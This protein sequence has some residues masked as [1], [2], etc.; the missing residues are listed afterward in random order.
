MAE[1]K[2]RSPLAA[3]TGGGALAM[4]EITGQALINLRGRADCEPFAAAVRD[5]LGAPLPVAPNTTAAAGGRRIFW[6]GPDE[7]LVRAP[8]TMRGEIFT[9]LQKTRAAAE[10]HAA[11]VDVSDYYTIIRIAGARARDAL[12]AGCPLDL[13]PQQ[14]AVGQCAQ[15]RFARAAI[16]LWHSSDAPEFEL[17]VRWSFAEYLWE[18]LE[19][20][21]RDYLQRDYLPPQTNSGAPAATQKAREDAP[22]T[23][24]ESAPKSMLKSASETASKTAPKNAS[25]SAS[26]TARKKHPQKTSPVSSPENPRAAGG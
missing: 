2:T 17:Q 22:K 6:L 20:H 26:K 21:E 12:A 15:S 9:A 14:F 19:A 4:Q 25:K 13:H 3:K 5:A 18:Y 8:E 11:V 16:L 10:G 23:A 1:I 24:R 7:W